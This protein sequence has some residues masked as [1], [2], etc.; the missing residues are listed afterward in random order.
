MSSVFM[1]LQELVN[2]GVKK[3]CLFLLVVTQMDGQA[4]FT[5]IAGYMLIIFTD[6]TYAV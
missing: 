1:C 4:E 2:N 3:V 5:W 6:I